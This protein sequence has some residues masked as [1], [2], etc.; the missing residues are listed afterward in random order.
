[1]LKKS[2]L[3][4]FV[5][6]ILCGT[7]SAQNS[8]ALTGYIVTKNNYHLTGAIGL[9]EH[10]QYGSMVE[11]INDFGT[12]YFLHP[13]LIRGFVFFEGPAISAYESK[14]YRNTWMFLR[15]QYSG[16][17]ISLLQTHPGSLGL[18]VRRATA[19]RICIPY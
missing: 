10:T 12:P 17:N 14:Y 5:I 2:T 15:L 4:L 16:E 19:S 1:M 18:L 9:I 7:L 13:A 6:G 11:F 3:L 8:E